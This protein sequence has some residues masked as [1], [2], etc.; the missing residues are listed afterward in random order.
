M[1]NDAGAKA[2]VASAI[3]R[4]IRDYNRKLQDQNVVG[5]VGKARVG[6]AGDGKVYAT[7]YDPITR[8]VTA[9]ILGVDPCPNVTLFT[10]CVLQAVS[11]AVGP[12]RATIRTPD[13]A[14][15]TLSSY[16]VTATMPLMTAGAGAD[17]DN[18]E[19]T[20]PNHAVAAYASSSGKAARHQNRRRC[21]L[22]RCCCCCGCLR[23]L[24]KV[25]NCVSI[26][27]GITVITIIIM[28]V[29]LVLIGQFGMSID[30]SANPWAFDG[31]P[32]FAAHVP[33]NTR[34]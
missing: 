29:V 26:T 33:G 2:L 32:L 24:G 34:Q 16:V 31:N 6:T 27:F 30:P 25:G 20:G 18:D 5:A 19:S 23:C 28:A 4:G 8:I 15:R 9:Y 10:Q 12:H 1:S 14:V 7:R 17:D 13:R 22:P 3:T 11:D 21:W